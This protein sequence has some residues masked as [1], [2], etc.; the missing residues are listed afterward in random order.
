MLLKFNLNLLKILFAKITVDVDIFQIVIDNSVARTESNAYKLQA[1]GE[2]MG[3]MFEVSILRRDD[4]ASHKGKCEGDD[5]IQSAG[6]KTSAG[7]ER[8]H[9]GPAAFL[10]VS[11]GLQKVLFNFLKVV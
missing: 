9:Q 8:G 6:K 3:D 7:T 1:C 10:I 5:L 4:F 2:V 11:S